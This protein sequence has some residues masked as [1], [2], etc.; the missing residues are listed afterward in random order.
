MNLATQLTQLESAQLV[1]RADDPS[2]GSGD[3]AYLFKHTLTQ[4]TT[5][6]SLLKKRRSEIHRAVAE[7]YEQ[8]YADR[9]DEFAALLA[10]HFAE[11]GDDE[12]TLEYSL[13]AG[14]AAAR[15]YANVE[16]IVQYTR[17]LEIAKRTPTLASHLQ[18]F[19]LKRGRMFELTSQHDLALANY[20]EMET[21]A[22]EQGNRAMEIAALMARATIYAIPTK[23]FDQAR[24]QTLCDHALALAR[25]IGDQPAQAKILWNM[26]LCNSRLASNF[27]EAIGYGEQALE[28]ARRLDLREQLAY[29][30]NDLSL[31][32]TYDGVPE[33]GEAV[34]LEA[35]QMW[36]EW[37]NLPMLADNLSYAAM[38]YIAI[39]QYEQA[40][41]AA[42]EAH[43]ISQSIGNVWGEAFSQT[44]VGQAYRE[45][46]Q[47][48]Q[49][50]AVMANAIRA[51]ALGFQPPLSF[52]RAD[53]ACLYGDL[54]MV[55]RGIELA[56]IAQTEGQKF[57]QTLDYWTR[58]RLAHLYLLDGQIAPAET[59]IDTVY[60]RLTPKDI[61]SLFSANLILA[62]AELGIARNDYPCAIQACDRLITSQRTRHLHQ[63]LPNALYLQGIAWQRAGNIDNALAAFTDARAEAENANAR[64][65]LWRILAALA[66][67]E[68][69]RGNPA[70]AQTLRAQ[71][72]EI[73][74]YIASHT[75]S[76]FRESFL[77]LPDVRAVY[78][79][80]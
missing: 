52:T 1:R 5:Y 68:I 18:N 39:A 56:Q 30:L 41:A 80:A 15:I 62:E 35:R 16:A 31:L 75:P 21:Y 20:E 17:A 64:W 11:A 47:I 9:L 36:R 61:S 57:A 65:S 63:F 44:W 26:V 70:P 12:K 69:A 54:G 13:R 46:G 77:K 73:I 71:A 40:I 25:A 72:R 14:D 22:R 79:S 32:Y 58:G 49:A 6:A 78:A 43:Q 48:E 2:A 45:L 50:M 59:L 27:H 66:E 55:A 7:S 33:H 34:N 19:Y 23:Q 4:E 28:I 76:E 53:L 10:Q 37:N 29:L 51:A 74:E 67:I 8:L 60:P 38:G 3:L 42:R 24:A